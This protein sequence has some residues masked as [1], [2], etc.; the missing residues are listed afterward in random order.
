MNYTLFYNLT[1]EILKKAIL[2]K[3]AML[4]T[5][6]VYGNHRQRGSSA[7]YVT[8]REIDNENTMELVAVYN[9]EKNRDIVGDGM[10]ETIG[11]MSAEYEI[12]R[13]NLKAEIFQDRDYDAESVFN[14]LIWMIDF[15]LNP[16][17]PQIRHSKISWTSTME[18]TNNYVL[19]KHWS[20]HGAKIVNC[21]YCDTKLPEFDKTRPKEPILMNKGR[22]DILSRRLK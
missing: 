16:C 4:K 18:T 9:R 20:D 3:Q 7:I 6:C 17:C 5:F 1:S 12:L 19:F 15:Y 13:L 10:D 2:A 14:E 11:E 21:P 8:P 22:F